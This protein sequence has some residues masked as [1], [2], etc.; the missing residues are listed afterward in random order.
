M[1]ERIPYSLNVDG[2]FY[3]EDGCCL[4]CDLPRAIAPDMFKFSKTNDHCYVYKQP[5]TNEE[6]HRM[7]EVVA[8]ADLGCIRY[9]GN[10]KRLIRYLRMKGCAEQ[11]DSDTTK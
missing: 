7:V 1:S 2:P 3:V 6:L 8:C 11:C 10:D 4:F 5:E 9:R